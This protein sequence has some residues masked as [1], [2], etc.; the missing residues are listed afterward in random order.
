[1]ESMSIHIR[2][3][4][5]TVFR[6]NITGRKVGVFSTKTPTNKPPRFNHCHYKHCENHCSTRANPGNEILLR[7]FALSRIHCATEDQ[8]FIRTFKPTAQQS[9][10]ITCCWNRLDYAWSLKDSRSPLH[11]CSRRLSLLVYYNR[12]VYFR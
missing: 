1:M 10:A 3:V 8:A 9:T 6:A 7:S 12:Y 2:L 5:F 11:Q 4:K